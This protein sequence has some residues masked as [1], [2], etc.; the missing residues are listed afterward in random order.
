M[1]PF[2]E[3]INVWKMGILGGLAESIYCGLVAS[4]LWISSN[5]NNAKMNELA[6]GVLVL[7]LLVFS[8]AVSGILVFGYPMYL[9]IE[10][11]YKEAFQTVGITLLTIMLVLITF[12]AV[13]V[14]FCSR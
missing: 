12:L 10:K 1:W 6:T 3:K 9:A 13:F 4:G 14:V 5:F 7:M 11:K 2:K 8:V